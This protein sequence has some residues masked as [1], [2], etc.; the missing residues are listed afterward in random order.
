MVSG[1][2]LN[3]FVFDLDGANACNFLQ[4]IV[5]CDDFYFYFLKFDMRFLLLL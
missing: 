3:Y 2:Y 5:L 4:I 1:S